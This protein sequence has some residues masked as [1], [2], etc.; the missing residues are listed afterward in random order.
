M[1]SI[2]PMEYN[3]QLCE[4]EG[5]WEPFCKSG[6]CVMQ[7]IVLNENASDEYERPKGESVI[8]EGDGGQLSSPLLQGEDCLRDCS[9]D[10]GVVD[11]PCPLGLICRPTAFQTKWGV[12]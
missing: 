9:P 6:E 10:D 12:S 5:E 3:A 1:F 7:V 11:V 8:M 2:V 4:H